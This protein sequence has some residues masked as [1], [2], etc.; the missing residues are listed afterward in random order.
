MRAEPSARGNGTSV[1]VIRALDALLFVNASRVAFW[2]ALYQ[3]MAGIF[4]A[5]PR[6][7]PLATRVLS[8][9]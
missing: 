9:V 2:Q 7:R 3:K 6:L 4:P 8:N 1:P 5:L